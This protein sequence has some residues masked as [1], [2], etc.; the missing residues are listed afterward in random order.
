MSSTKF[1]DPPVLRLESSDVLVGED[2]PWQA[3]ACVQWSVDQGMQAEGYRIAAQRLAERAPHWHEQ[4][5]LLYPIVFLY[6][7]YVELELKGLIAMG[8][9]LAGDSVAVPEVHDLRRLWSIAKPHISRE[10]DPRDRGLRKQ[11]VQ[12]ERVIGELAALDPRSTAFRYATDVHEGRPL[13]NGAHRLNLQQFA[14]TMAKLGQGLDDLGIG[15][16]LSLEQLQEMAEYY[17]P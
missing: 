15:M 8:Q 7:H 16:G 5:F 4:D 6:R 2:G 10:M 3:N 11:I 14:A 12:V 13:P 17:G 9:R 1:L